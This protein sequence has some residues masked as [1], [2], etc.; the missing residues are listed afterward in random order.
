[1]WIAFYLFCYLKRI[2]VYFNLINC[3]RISHLLKST[4]KFMIN[5]FC[6]LQIGERL[7]SKWFNWLYFNVIFLF[8]FYFLNRLLNWIQVLVRLILIRSIFDLYRLSLRLRQ[9]QVKFNCVAI[10][11]MTMIRDI[12]ISSLRLN[13]NE[14]ALPY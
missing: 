10:I 9:F 3:L 13:V 6:L 1:M 11:G 2:F 7:L 14:S 5:C 4:K 12:F 8:C